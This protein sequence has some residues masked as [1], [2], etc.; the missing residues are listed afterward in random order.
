M[1]DSA[2]KRGELIRHLEDALALADEI[3]DGQT[4]FLIERTLDEARSRQLDRSGELP[5][6]STVAGD[7]AALAASV[8]IAERFCITR[9][10]KGWSVTDL[11]PQPSSPR[12]LSGLR[13][14][15]SE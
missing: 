14:P 2:Q 12:S 8:P 5:L 3:Q 11:S 9:T 6:V 15:P 10:S 4:G 1:I 13:Q 7:V